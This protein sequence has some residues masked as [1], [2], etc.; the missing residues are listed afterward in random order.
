MRM[1][2]RAK[3]IIIDDDASSRRGALFEIFELI[4]LSYLVRWYRIKW[5]PMKRFPQLCV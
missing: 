4:G 1:G 2:K 3:L 5:V